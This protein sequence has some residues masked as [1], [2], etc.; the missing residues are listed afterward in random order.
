MSRHS[1]S[2]IPGPRCAAKVRADAFLSSRVGFLN[3]TEALVTGN[4]QLH[5]M[6]WYSNGMEKEGSVHEYPAWCHLSSA[7]LTSA[8]GWGQGNAVCP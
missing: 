7:H 6:Y 1:L 3:H 4:Y 2:N 8:A 5:Q